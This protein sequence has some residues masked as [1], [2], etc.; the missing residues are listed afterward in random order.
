MLFKRP[1]PALLPF[2]SAIVEVHSCSTREEVLRQCDAVHEAIVRMLREMPDE[3]LTAPAYPEGW[4]AAKNIKHIAR[5]NIYF[6][7]YIGAPA[8][9]LKLMGTAGKARRIEDMPATNRPLNFDYGS[10][11]QAGTARPGLKESLI[12]DLQAS[13]EKL[14]AAINQRSEEELD[15]FKGLFGGMDLRT[16]AL[17]VIKHAAHHSGVVKT[18]LKSAAVA[19]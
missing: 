14:K 19:V 7:W 5:S 12:E 6:S 3:Y 11:Q 17:F 13:A 15:R 10:Y 2:V 16:F 9:F 18:R 8:W 4:P 1:A